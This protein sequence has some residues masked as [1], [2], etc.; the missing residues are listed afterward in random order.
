MKKTWCGAFFAVMVISLGLACA[1]ASE[2]KR[3][4]YRKESMEWKGLTRTYILYLPVREFEKHP[5]LVIALHGGGGTAQKMAGFTVKG[6]QKMADRDEFLLCYPDGVEGHWND[7]RGISEYRAHKGNIDDVGFLTAL[8]DSLVKNYGVDPARVYVTGASNGALMAYRL[9]CE[10]TGK[11]A[12]IAPVICPMG[13]AVYKGPKPAMPIS[14][15][16][17]NGTDDPLAPYK[18]GDIH[19]GKKTLGKAVSTK[20]TVEYFVKLN[21][22][23]KA[24]RTESLPDADPGDGCTATVETYGSGREGTE[25]ILYTIKNGGHTWPGGT[26]YLPEKVVGKVCRDFD[27][28]SVIWEFFKRHHR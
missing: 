7:G 20:E 15:M 22:C 21:G 4:P 18:G 12:A 5:P 10:A 2:E 28:A 14:V 19:L 24:P 3:S 13:E 6:F 11:I 27:G 25:V 16:I 9:A 17:I 26:Q 23:E 1:H 8:I